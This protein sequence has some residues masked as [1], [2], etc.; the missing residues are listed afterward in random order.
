MVAFF[1]MQCISRAFWR[2]ASGAR[3]QG[4]DYG[5]RARVHGGMGQGN[6]QTGHCRFILTANGRAH[7]GHGRGGGGAR[8]GER[9]TELQI[10]VIGV[11]HELSSFLN[12]PDELLLVLLP[13]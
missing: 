10:G 7:R 12:M 2:L 9:S 6:W 8:L 1:V 13:Q 5:L 11:H 3:G 4:G